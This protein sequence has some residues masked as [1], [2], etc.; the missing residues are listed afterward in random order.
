LF[1]SRQRFVEDVA[2]NIGCVVSLA[3]AELSDTVKD[4]VIGASNATKSDWLATVA[5]SWFDLVQE[6]CVCKGDSGTGV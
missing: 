4:V 5:S 3:E 2:K 6:C 1:D